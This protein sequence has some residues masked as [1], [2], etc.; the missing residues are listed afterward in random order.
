MFKADQWQCPLLPEQF[1]PHF[2]AWGQPMQVAPRFFALYRYQM[3]EPA[4]AARI[5]TRMKFTIV[6][7]LSELDYFLSAYSAFSFLSVF[8]I[9]AIIM[10]AI[11]RT[12]TRPAIAAAMLREAGFAMRVPMVYTRYDTV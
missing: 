9:K 11:T 1:P 3:I 10:P 5:T 2:F 6:R 7:V 12:A 8:L 4:M